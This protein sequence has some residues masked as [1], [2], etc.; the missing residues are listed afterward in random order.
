M[1][2]GSRVQLSDLA[3]KEKIDP[4]VKNRENRMGTIVGESYDGKCFIV[5]WD[6]NKYCKAGLPSYNARFLVEK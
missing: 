6:G 5:L 2:K 1:Q 3:L 4:R